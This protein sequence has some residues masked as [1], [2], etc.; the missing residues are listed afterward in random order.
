MSLHTVDF[1]S[2]SSSSVSDDDI[3]VLEV[4]RQK[5][6][7]QQPTTQIIERPPPIQKQ[8]IRNNSSRYRKGNPQRPVQPRRTQ[9]NADLVDDDQDPFAEEDR[10]DTPVTRKKKIRRIRPLNQHPNANDPITNYDPEAHSTPIQQIPPTP[11]TPI[12]EHSASQI[13][14]LERTT[15]FGL[16]GRTT[17]FR[18]TENSAHKYSAKTKGSSPT[19]VTIS[20]HEESHLSATSDFVLLIA[21]DSKDFS[22]RIGSENGQE[23]MTVRFASPKANQITRIIFV[24]FFR[25]M[26]GVPESIRSKQPTKSEDGKIIHDFEGKFAHESVKNTVLWD[27]QKQVNLVFFKKTGKNAFE[28]ESRLPLEPVY[29]FGIALSCSLSK[30]K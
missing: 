9:Q 13:Y 5:T 3:P 1:K 7:Y 30:V 2:Q 16:K 25:E 23:L 19:S 27:V 15:S 6:R 24:S 21:N 28:V 12:T 10:N 22:L 20:S 26:E 29:L 14:L 8:I 17:T 18:F 4:V 11:T